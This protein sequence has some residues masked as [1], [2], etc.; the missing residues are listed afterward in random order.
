M[1]EI[2]TAEESR[3]ISEKFDNSLK[4]MLS[5]IN[6]RANNGCIYASF[7]RR[8][9]VIT[10]RELSAL[11]NLGYKIVEDDGFYVRVEW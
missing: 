5:T 10:E 7:T 11:R 9:R 8:D 1:S 2:P 4:D 6:A 3:I